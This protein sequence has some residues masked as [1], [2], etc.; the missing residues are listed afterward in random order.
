MR[1]CR[2]LAALLLSVTSC[3]HLKMGLFL[4]KDNP[5]ANDPAAVTRGQAAYAANCASCHG[6]DGDGRGSQA[7]T[8]STPPTNF[9]DSSSEG[10]SRIAARI[11]YG[12][13]SAMPA[14]RETL[15]ENE[16]WDIANYVYSIQRP[17]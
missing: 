6:D 17:N 11:A 14:F 5:S 1:R 16:I 12:K 10:A 13:G 15:S 9:R 8:L 7:A 4:L 3:S 2:L